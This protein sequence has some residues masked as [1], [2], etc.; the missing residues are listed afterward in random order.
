[1]TE[2]ARNV[3]RLINRKRRGQEEDRDPFIA[4][5][6]HENERGSLDLPP[7]TISTQLQ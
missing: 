5:L 1:M 7:E 6:V 3:S 4:V 2:T